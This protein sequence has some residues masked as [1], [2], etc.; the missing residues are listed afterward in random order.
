MTEN[1]KG[2]WKIAFYYQKWNRYDGLLI[3]EKKSA[4]FPWLA[5]IA[6]EHIQMQPARAAA[7]LAMWKKLFFPHFIDREE[8]DSI[9]V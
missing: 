9:N 4:T 5:G 1:Y 7:F 6:E 8:C 3:P 2:I